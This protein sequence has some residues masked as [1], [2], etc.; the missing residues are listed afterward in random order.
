MQNHLPLVV[1]RDLELLCSE[2]T[3]P[4][5]TNQRKVVRLRCIEEQD[6][7]TPDQWNPTR[8][9]FWA[10]SHTHQCAHTSDGY[11]YGGRGMI[12]EL[13]LVLRAYDESLKRSKTQIL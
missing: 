8:P 11:H 10:C 13:S 5:F 3:R 6:L 12:R 9:N 7:E 4:L 2:S 1:P